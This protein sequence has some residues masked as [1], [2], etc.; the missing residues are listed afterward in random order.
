LHFQCPDVLTLQLYRC[1]IS[2]PG[3]EKLTVI[4]GDR[5]VYDSSELM[6]ELVLDMGKRYDDRYIFFDAP[7][8]L[9]RSEAIS[10]APMMDG[11]IM[12]VEAG[13][14]SKKDVRSKI[15]IKNF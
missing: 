7:P 10:M 14:T 11:V 4:S 15:K 8:I 2:W 1:G 3:I 5:T 6:E 12:V 9:G 13:R